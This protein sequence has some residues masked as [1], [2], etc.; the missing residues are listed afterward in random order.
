MMET[1]AHYSCACAFIYIDMSEDDGLSN[2]SILY[3]C[4]YLPI[5]DR[6]HILPVTRRF[7]NEFSAMALICKF[8]NLML[9]VFSTHPCC[10]FVDG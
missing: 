3:T 8:A 5:H 1:A 10:L 2:G 6:Y 7:Q 9:D 4:L